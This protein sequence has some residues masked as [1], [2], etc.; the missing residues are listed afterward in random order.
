MLEAK[1]ATYDPNADPNI[2]G[3][4]YKTLFVARLSYEVTER[5]LMREFEEF[6]PVRRVRIVHDKVTGTALEGLH[7]Q[8][9]ARA[10]GRCT[11]SSRQACRCKDL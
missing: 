5:K 3:D 7:C 2:D 8:G 10:W 11:G 1:T 4:P 6:G 9:W